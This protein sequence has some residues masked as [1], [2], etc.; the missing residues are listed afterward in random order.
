[1]PVAVPPGSRVVLTDSACAVF[2]RIV[3]AGPT[4]RPLLSEALRFSK[5]TMSA[6]V[7]ELTELGLVGPFGSSQRGVGRRATV[8]G[9][10]RE[11]GH[12]I[13]VDA[14][15]TEVRAMAQTLDGRLLAEADEPMPRERLHITSE[16][17][18]AIRNVLAALRGQIG[19]R[20]GPLRAIAVAVPVIVSPNRPELAHRTDLDILRESIAPLDDVELV[21]ENNVNCAA[22]AEMHL[23]A[24]CSRTS[25]AYLQVGV[26]IGLGIVHEGRLFRGFNGAAGEVARL[27]FPWSDDR[28]PRRNGLETY[29]G[30]H[31]LMT[32]VRRSWPKADGPAPRTARALFELAAAGS[33]SGRHH[34][35]LHAA[36]IGQ[37]VAAIV[38]MI[39]PGL[40]VL[41]GG[42]GQNPLLLGEVTKVV[43]QLAWPTEI[44]T[45]P[46]GR[47][48][49]VLGA[50]Q[51]AVRQV[52]QTL[53]GP[54]KLPLDGI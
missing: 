21:L 19:D 39:D 18:A 31:Q 22:I 45:S 32:R 30:S 44:A 37:L 15:A 4:T 20:H 34:V 5:P 6:A 11:A 53:T 12:I 27:P 26:K 16:T 35:T 8:Y 38:G 24:A 9:L 41:G 52:L 43:R 47:S 29:L 50:C 10:G 25:F 36:D 13:G 2:Q 3:L 54:S 33:P 23:G 42:V 17:G 48:G 49:S 51:L 14:G 46:L 28:K 1:M 40:I 7:S